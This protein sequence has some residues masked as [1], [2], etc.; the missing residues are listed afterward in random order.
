VNIKKLKAMIVD[1]PDDMPVV[2]CRDGNVGSW[3]HSPNLSVRPVYKFHMVLNYGINKGSLYQV[4][5]CEVPPYE[6]NGRDVISQ[7][8]ALVFYTQE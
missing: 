7:Y 8:D 1:L 4:E 3:T 6:N 2:E 5:F